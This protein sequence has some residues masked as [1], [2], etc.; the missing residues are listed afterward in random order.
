MKEQFETAVLQK[1]LVECES[2]EARITAT[3]HSCKTSA[4]AKTHYKLLIRNF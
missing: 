2:D 3:G 4:C 1:Y